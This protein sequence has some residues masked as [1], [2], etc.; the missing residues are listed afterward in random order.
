MTEK[1]LQQA[2]TDAAQLLGWLVYHTHDSRHS[3]KGFP[4]LVMVRGGRLLFVELKAEKGKLSPEQRAW[5]QAL[6]SVSVEIDARIDDSFVENTGV[7]E[8]YV[9]HPTDLDF[10]LSV[11]K[12]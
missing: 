6:V 11:L 9:W 10:A 12:G 2:I 3:A 7:V 4:D 5:F 8:V 1:Q